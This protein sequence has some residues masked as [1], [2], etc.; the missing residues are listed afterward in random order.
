MLLAKEFE[1]KDLGHLRYF[2]GMEVARSKFGIYLSQRKY[3]FD[4]LQEAGMLGCR[5]TDTPMEFN[6]KI[7]ERKESQPTDKVK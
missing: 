3:I 4:L 6:V 1:V 2:L 7:G 5:S